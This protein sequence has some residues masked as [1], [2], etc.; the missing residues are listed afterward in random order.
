MTISTVMA[1]KITCHI[2]SQS[3]VNSVKWVIVNYVMMI[4]I[5]I[6]ST[7]SHIIHVA[8]QYNIDESYDII[9]EPFSNTVLFSY[10]IICWSA[11]E[12]GYPMVV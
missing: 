5:V 2:Q 12:D 10:A 11:G 1:H 9:Y 4:K 7:A 8:V 6:F 3:F